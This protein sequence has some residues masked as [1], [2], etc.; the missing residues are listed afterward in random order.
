MGV[1]GKSEGK[2]AKQRGRE[3]LFSVTNGD[4][5]MAAALKYVARCRCLIDHVAIHL[6]GKSWDDPVALVRLGGWSRRGSAW[7][8][9]AMLCEY[10]TAMSAQVQQQAFARA[11]EQTT[12]RPLTAELRYTLV[13]RRNPMWHQEPSPITIPVDTFAAV[14]SAAASCAAEVMLILWVRSAL[15]TCGRR[16]WGAGIRQSCSNTQTL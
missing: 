4:D 16:G 2:P 5:S 7:P 1:K 9:N 3:D 15:D 12:A 6:P 8:T 14:S 10:A 11:E 13:G